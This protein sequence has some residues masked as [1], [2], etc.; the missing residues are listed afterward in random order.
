MECAA[1][2]RVATPCESGPPSRRCGVCGVVSYCSS[3][4]QVS[5]LR[6]PSVG[7]LF[8]DI[9][10][11]ETI[12]HLIFHFFPYSFPS[13]FCEDVALGI[14]Q[15]GMS[16]TRGTNEASTFHIRFSFHLL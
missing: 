16:T 13:V 11:G 4:H 7:L 6:V 10:I 2:G 15:G 8:A 5:D 1:K 12:L 9:T 14:S 3:S